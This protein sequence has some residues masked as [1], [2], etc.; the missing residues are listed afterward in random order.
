MVIL[1]WN[2]IEQWLVAAIAVAAIAVFMYG[3]LA[4]FLFPQLAPDWAAEITVFLVIWAVMLSASTLAGEHRHVRAD[5]IIRILPRA[6]RIT[7]EG[8]NLL[9]SITF[10]AAMAWSGYLV[11][12]FALLL[13]E[14]S[15]STI[16][17]P[18][19]Y[20]YLCVPVAMSLMTVRFAIRFVQLVLTKGESEMAAGDHH[21][22]D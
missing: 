20:Y 7:A 4:R 12:D 16:R 9:I 2:R 5:L 6:T 13:D 19:F 15:L 22:I 14:R 10:C 8:F 3:M 18:I 17:I 11:V 21:V 1:W